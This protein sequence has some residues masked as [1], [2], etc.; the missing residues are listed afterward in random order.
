[1]LQTC[2]NSLIRRVERDR[3]LEESELAETWIG[4]DFERA[5]ANAEDM[6]YHVVRPNSC[7]VLEQVPRWG[8]DCS[9]LV[10]RFPERG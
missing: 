9:Q 5:L 2:K 6:G 7:V 10:I 1:M 3:E 8:I 4:V